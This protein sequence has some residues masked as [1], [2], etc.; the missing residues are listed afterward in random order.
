METDIDITPS[1]FDQLFELMKGMKYSEA[2]AMLN[3]ALSQIG[4]EAIIH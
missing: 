2:E 3:L 1:K 4:N